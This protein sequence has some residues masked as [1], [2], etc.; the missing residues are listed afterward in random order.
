MYAEQI[1]LLSD[2][3][4][5]DYTIRPASSGSLALQSLEYAIPDIILLDFR[6][7]DMD[8]YE[9]ISKFKPMR[10]PATSQSYLLVLWTTFP[11]K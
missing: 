8:G 7:P 2:I 1:S 9:G 4:S 6:M 10:I 3:L 5:P 11:I